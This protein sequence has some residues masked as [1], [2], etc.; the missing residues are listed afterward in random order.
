MVSLETFQSG[1]FHECIYAPAETT[2]LSFNQPRSV[3]SAAFTL[4]AQREALCVMF[5]PMALPSVNVSIIISEI[6]IEKEIFKRK[7]NVQY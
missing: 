4:L 5:N 6:S 1:W 3:H 7:L 2:K